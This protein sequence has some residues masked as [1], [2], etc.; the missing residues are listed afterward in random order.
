[1]TEQ[2][3]STDNHTDNHKYSPTP[4]LNIV[5]NV[6][7]RYQDQKNNIINQLK[8]SKIEKGEYKKL[9]CVAVMG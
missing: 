3:H 8:N 9:L 6:K 5:L 2:Q 4:K 1:M 7:Q